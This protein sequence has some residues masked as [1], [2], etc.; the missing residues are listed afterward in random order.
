MMI[1]AICKYSVVVMLLLF[2]LA[3]PVHAEDPALMLNPH[4][5]SQQNRCLIDEGHC[6][7]LTFHATFCPLTH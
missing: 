6:E 2:G 3:L 4:V 1:R 5:S 7:V